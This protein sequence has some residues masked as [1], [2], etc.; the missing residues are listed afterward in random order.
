MTSRYLAA[1]SNSDLSVATSLKMSP[2]RCILMS[3]YALYLSVNE[4][5]VLL[6]RNGSHLKPHDPLHQAAPKTDT[7]SSQRLWFQLFHFQT[8][9]FLVIL[10]C[11]VSIWN[12]L[13]E[14]SAVSLEAVS[15]DL[16][17]AT[18]I[19]RAVWAPHL[20]L[21]WFRND[22]AKDTANMP[23]I[24]EEFFLLMWSAYSWGDPVRGEKQEWRRVN[25]WG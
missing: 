19:I 20:S 17:F 1:Y 6:F 4:T 16:C 12:R 24:W 22:A 25:I 14:I 9:T 7:T 5:H 8:L 15:E 18:A 21:K 2:Q 11:P 23:R 3:V 13:L 10:S